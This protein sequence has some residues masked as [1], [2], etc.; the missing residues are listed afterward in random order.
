MPKVASHI[1][2]HGD[3]DSDNNSTIYAEAQSYARTGR[4]GIRAVWMRGVDSCIIYR[5]AGAWHGILRD[6]YVDTKMQARKG[7]GSSVGWWIQGGSAWEQ[8]YRLSAGW[9]FVCKA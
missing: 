1:H 2:R 6:S 3:G 5:L 9:M 7:T 4:G 8:Y